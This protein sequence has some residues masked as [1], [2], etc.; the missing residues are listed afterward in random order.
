MDFGFRQ[1]FDVGVVD[2]LLAICQLLELLEDAL[3][4]ILVQVVA[5]ILHAVA[6]R[7]PATVLAQHQ[8]R[9]GQADVLGPHDL[10]GGT[11]L[12]H[13]VLMDAGFVGERIL[14]DDRLV[15]LHGDAGDVRH[16]P[17]RGAEA[18]R[19]DP[20][21][22]LEVIA[23]RAHGHHDL[24]QSTVAG[25]LTPL[26]YKRVDVGAEPRGGAML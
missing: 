24:L 7:V 14:A 22:Q 11:L 20:G 15:A 13:A 5:Q 9:A 3:E 19:V 16:Q 23:A 17:A 26:F 2:F 10:V 12:E 8:L 18:A 4:L 21:L 1:R 6:E 25:P